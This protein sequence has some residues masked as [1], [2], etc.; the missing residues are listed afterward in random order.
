MDV[1][2]SAINQT[3][4]H[5]LYHQDE[6]MYLVLKSFFVNVEYAPPEISNEGPY[7]HNQN[8]ENEYRI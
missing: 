2:I 4:G 7:I 8:L 5:L 3:H 1:S 6:S